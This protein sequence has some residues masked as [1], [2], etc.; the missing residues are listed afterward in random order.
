M[1]KMLII[2]MGNKIIPKPTPK[3]WAAVTKSI[4]LII[5]AVDI[6]MQGDEIPNNLIVRFYKEIII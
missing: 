4:I 1:P 6:L 2:S 3:E 5:K